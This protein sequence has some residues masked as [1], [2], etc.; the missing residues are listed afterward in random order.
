MR[1]STGQIGFFPGVN[2]LGRQLAQTHRISLV[3]P[4]SVTTAIDIVTALL[5]FKAG[6]PGRYLP[7]ASNV[8]LE[9]LEVTGFGGAQPSGELANCLNRTSRSPFGMRLIELER[10]LPTVDHHVPVDIACSLGRRGFVGRSQVKAFAPAGQLE[11][12]TEITGLFVL[13]L[14]A[15]ALSKNLALP[16]TDIIPGT[17]GP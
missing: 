14:L 9:C 4:G 2:L 15:V 1:A 17:A 16:I 5:L 13:A 6:D 12:R 8:I 10:L 11:P 3:N 7:K